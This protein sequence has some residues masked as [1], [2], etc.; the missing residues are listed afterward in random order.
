MNQERSE[1]PN[2]TDPSSTQA[3]G[4]ES[5]PNQISGEFR[6]NVERYV[7]LSLLYSGICNNKI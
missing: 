4:G 2:N 1:Q 7:L 5:Y 6:Q 3:S